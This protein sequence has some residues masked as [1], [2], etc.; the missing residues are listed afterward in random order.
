MV[1]GKDKKNIHFFDVDEKYRVIA[2]FEKKEN[3]PWF[4]MATLGPIKKQYRVYGIIHFKIKNTSLQLNLY[5]SQ[6]LMLNE[7]YKNLLFLPFTDA[8]TGKETYEGG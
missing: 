8:T 5:Q 6:T 2:S 1:K 3:M 4:Q 7:Q